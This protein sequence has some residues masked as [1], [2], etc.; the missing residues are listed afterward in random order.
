LFIMSPKGG[1]MQGKEF[2]KMV[3]KALNL[4]ENT[5]LEIGKINKF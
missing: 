1:K 5:K 4:G 3:K 2:K